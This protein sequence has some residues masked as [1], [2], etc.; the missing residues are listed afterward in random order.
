MRPESSVMARESSD[1][2]LAGDKLIDLKN[3]FVVTVS[4]LGLEKNVHLLAGGSW[5]YK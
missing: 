2:S 3:L 1:G 4:C 5:D